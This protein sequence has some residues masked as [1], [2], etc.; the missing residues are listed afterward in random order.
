M[1][2]LTAIPVYNEERHLEGVLR[3]V[4]RYSPHILVVNDGSTDRTAELLARATD[5]TVITHPQNRGYGAALMSA[6][7]YALDQGVDVLVTMDCDGQHE[8]ARIPVLLEA[9]DDA[10]IVSGSRYLRD[11]RQDS[12]PPQDRRQINRIVTEE[13]NQLLG[14]NLT[15]AFCGFKAYRR[16]ALA[17]LHI[18]ET[19]WGM[20]LQLWV[21]AARQGL[22][23]EEIGVPRLYLDPNRAFGGVLD[24]ATERLAHYRRVIAAAVA[25]CG[26]RPGGGRPDPRIHGAAPNGCSTLRNPGGCR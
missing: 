16:E 8:P 13:L 20:P 4:R 19:G 6:F 17:K 21:Q 24:D 7:A 23:I 14:L 1:K 26:P 10:D 9:I 18:T 25:E 22:R 12:A 3:E 15:D 11:F 2:L 5:L